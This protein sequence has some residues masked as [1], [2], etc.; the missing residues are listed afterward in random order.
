[1][2]EA[3]GVTRAAIWKAVGALRGRGLDVHAVAGKGYRLA[4]PIEWLD[5][6]RLID[7][8]PPR[9]RERV[10][11]FELMRTAASTNSELLAGPPP[12][13]GRARVCIAEFQTSGRGRHGRSWSS[14]PGA[15][16]SFSVAWRFEL[17]P[18]RLSSLSLAAGV[19]LAG[20]LSGPG[21]GPGLKWPNDLVWQGGKVGGILTELSGEAEGA[22]TAVVGVG[23]NHR[24]PPRWAP[25]GTPADG[26]EPT[27][28]K[29]VLGSRLPGRNALAAALIAGL[30]DGFLR[31][32]REGFVPFARAWQ[33]LDV[34]QGQPVTV[35]SRSL[36]TAGIARGIDLSGALLLEGM[37]G[38]VRI[39]TGDVS[40]RLSA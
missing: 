9:A 23:I 8:L 34:L 4:R 21:G 30:V 14:P 18:Q 32:E 2:A 16:L 20:S 7:A 19:A 37:D 39:Y 27:D 1:M 22:T 36:Q 6:K 12:A 15:G 26:L 31:F 40:A 11:R 17:P 10:E 28:L 3:E 24:L 29:A 25:D 13:P 38:L 5:Q 33:E 35:S